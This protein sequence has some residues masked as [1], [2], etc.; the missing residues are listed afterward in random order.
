[1]KLTKRNQ[2]KYA[3]VEKMAAASMLRYPFLAEQAALEPAMFVRHQDI[4]E[5]VTRYDD[6]AEIE[7]RADVSEVKEINVASEEQAR[8]WCNRLA[9]F[10]VAALVDSAMSSLTSGDYGDSPGLE[11]VARMQQLLADLSW[12][13]GKELLP[14]MADIADDFLDA[15]RRE[16]ETGE[17]S[18]IRIGLSVFD[19]NLKGLRPADVTLIA[20]EG[21]CG[22]TAMM[23]YVARKAAMA[24]HT[25]FMASGEMSESQLGER[26]AGNVLGKSP[27]E[28]WNTLDEVQLALDLVDMSAEYMSRIVVDATPTILLHELEG[29]VRQFMDV[30]GCSLVIVDHLDHV[31]TSASHDMYQ[32]TST[33]IRSL[34]DMA[35]RL[36]VHIIV[37][38]HINRD[39]EKS[40]GNPSK[41]WLRGS[42]HLGQVP[43]NIIILTRNVVQGATRTRIWVLKARMGFTGNLWVDYN[44][45]YGVYMEAA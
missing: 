30:R 21:G 7:L 6:V 15:K 19:K 14:S 39:G 11:R 12:R 33:A 5:A 36:G 45:S 28:S 38:G 2:Q 10:Y 17:S 44:P 16:I 24:G 9:D 37:L 27:A 8:I 22:K 31:F 32:Q 13:K 26:E 18:S 23:Q 40:M 4:F 25:V 3:T 1:M 34:K 43:D 35:K 20:A 29:K 42:T 41:S